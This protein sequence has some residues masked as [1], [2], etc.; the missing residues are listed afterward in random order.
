MRNSGS[1]TQTANELPERTEPS[2]QTAKKYTL[3][4]WHDIKVTKPPNQAIVN[5]I[6]KDK[7]VLY[8]YMRIPTGQ[9]IHAEEMGER[10]YNE[11]Q[12]LLWSFPYF[13][14]Y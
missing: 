11:D 8:N 14:Y 3:L 10:I 2:T 1:Q 9:F 12:V 7:E 6:L 5:I 13:N 4:H